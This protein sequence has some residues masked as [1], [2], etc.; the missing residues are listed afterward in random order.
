MLDKHDPLF[1]TKALNSLK[2]SGEAA[3]VNTKSYG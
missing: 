2:G 3:A 1:T